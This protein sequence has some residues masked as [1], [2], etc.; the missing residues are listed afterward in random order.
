MRYQTEEEQNKLYNQ[1]SNKFSDNSYQSNNSV[2]QNNN[3]FKKECIYVNP[4][5]YI[6]YCLLN[7]ISLALGCFLK[8]IHPLNRD[9][10]G[11]KSIITGI[12]IIRN[13][14]FVFPM[15]LNSIYFIW[16]IS[17]YYTNPSIRVKYENIFKYLK[18]YRGVFFFT[19]I[20]F[21]IIFYVLYY[22]V[23]LSI[24]NNYGFKLSGYVIASV[25]SGGMIVNLHNI[26]ESFINNNNIDPNFNKYISYANTFLYYHS[27][28][29]IFWSAWIFHQ[30]PELIFAF[31]ISV[32]F[33][34]FAHVI[35][36]DELFLNLIDPYPRRNP[37]ILYK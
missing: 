4:S 25:L 6:M 33:L 3:K 10:F 29:T 18:I 31:L 1:S 5:I 9:S 26:Y 30:V 37:V 35:N 23:V 20:L 15:L 32:I 22:L 8:L 34:V 7:G 12:P 28:Y 16:F 36:V 14:Y 13:Y 17:K 27:I 19:N 24:Y 2:F 21:L 11:K